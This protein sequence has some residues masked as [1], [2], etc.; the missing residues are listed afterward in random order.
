MLREGGHALA[1]TTPGI[2]IDWDEDAVKARLLQGSR[3]EVRPA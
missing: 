2:G 1:P 3:F